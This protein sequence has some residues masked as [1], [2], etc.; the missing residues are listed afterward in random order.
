MIYF[1]LPSLYNNFEINDFFVNLSNYYSHFFKYKVVFS[2]VTGNFPFCYWNGG[3]NNNIDGHNIATYE[4]FVSCAEEYSAPIRFNCANVCLQENDVNDTMAN[5]ILSV[6]Q[7]GSNSIE[8]SNLEIYETLKKKYP[9]YTYVFSKEADLVFPMTPEIINIIDKECDFKLISLPE[10]K[11]TDMSF[12]EAIS[13]PSKIELSVN[14]VCNK[15][16]VKYK[17]C[18]MH[19]H[20]SQYDFSEVNNYKRCQEHSSYAERA[21]MITMDDIVAKYLPK[22]FNHFTLA[23][24]ISDSRDNLINFLVNYFIKDENKAEV[25]EMIMKKGKI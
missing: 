14:T 13:N 1:T 5:L 19:E 18:K 16:C 25:Y 15:S 21:P 23:E 6:N 24:V 3:Y 7:T 20:Q 12:L 22:G 4:D 9:E 11:T 10:D 8:L 17:Q 2:S